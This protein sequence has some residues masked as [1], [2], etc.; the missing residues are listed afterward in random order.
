MNGKTLCLT[1]L[2]LLNKDRSCKRYRVFKRYM[3]AVP[4]DEYGEVSNCLQKSVK[5]VS[6]PDESAEIEACLLRGRAPHTLLATA[7]LAGGAVVKLLPWA[8]PPDE[9][10]CQWRRE[11]VKKKSLRCRLLLSC[12]PWCTELRRIKF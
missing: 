10:W 9:H 8:L 11:V 5:N 1:K 6:R 2:L 4:S 7:S 12:R 3:A